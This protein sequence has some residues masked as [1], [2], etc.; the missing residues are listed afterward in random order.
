MYKVEPGQ[1]PGLV[2]K[3]LS[4][5]PGPGPDS[6]VCARVGHFTFLDS[7][8][9]PVDK[10]A[11]PKD[12]GPWCLDLISGGRSVSGREGSRCTQCFFPQHFILENFKH[13]E[14][15]L[16]KKKKLKDLFGEKS[17]TSHLDSTN[18]I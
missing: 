4:S 13:I 15:K 5:C 17:F 2:G 16:E 9:S 7:V 11:E 6:T 12:Q 1:G 14:K 10:Y 3:E 18:N 8:F